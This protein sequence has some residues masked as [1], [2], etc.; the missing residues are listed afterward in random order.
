MIGVAFSP[1]DLAALIAW[2]EE[3]E[4]QRL[5]SEIAGDGEAVPE[6]LLVTLP[7]GYQPAFSLWTMSNG[8]Y[9]LEDWR[10][11]GRFD[12]EVSSC[13]PTLEAALYKIETEVAQY[14]K[15]LPRVAV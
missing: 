2:S 11:L 4:A 6:N 9:C 15:A 7:G 10:R 1:D 5:T 12:A 3:A 13:H 14:G 8:A